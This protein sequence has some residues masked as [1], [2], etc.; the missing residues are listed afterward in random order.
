[1][2]SYIVR[3]LVQ[4]V[5][6]LLILTFIV[7][8]LMQ[9]LPGDP[10]ASLFGNMPRTQ[11]EYQRIK[12]EFWL[13]RPVLVQYFHWL[14]RVLNGDFGRSIIERRDVAELIRRSLPIT[15][16]L[17]CS[18]VVLAA[19]IGIP[20]GI[21]AA[22]RRGG[23]IDS[24]INTLANV[25]IGIPAFWLGIMLIYLIAY[26]L[27]LLPISGYTSPFDDFWLYL[28]KMILPVITLSFSF[29]AII[30]RQMRSS[31][32]EVIYQD[33]IR[34]AW[35][36]GLSE[37]LIVSRHAVKN[38]LIPVVTTLGV[39][40]GHLVGGTVL[41]ETVFNIPGMGRLIV[42]SIWRNEFFVMQ[43]CI[44]IVGFIVAVVNLIVDILYTW[45][46]PKIRLE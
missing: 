29:I 33:Y 20:L 39:T 11:E 1:M 35:A 27:E 28:R 23:I 21:I 17:S 22:T 37:R 4:T 42:Q 7:F 2:L 25:V 18:A 9:L 46:D 24:V 8:M 36:K 44:L 30:A 32:L 31:T 5:F 41:I 14:H 40:L 45:L 6:S 38:A 34:T 12:H 26:R 19:L 16:N 3:R 10:V 13:D 15:L 43:G